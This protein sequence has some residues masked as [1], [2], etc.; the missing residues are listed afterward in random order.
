M[1][2]LFARSSRLA[3]PCGRSLKVASL[4]MEVGYASTAPH[5]WL[6]GDNRA[7]ADYREDGDHM[8][9]DVR[10]RGR[11]HAVARSN[12]SPSSPFAPALCL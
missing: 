8:P 5:H 12:V 2:P 11:E 9:V 1:I 6:Q 4:Q 7:G 3:A 10:L